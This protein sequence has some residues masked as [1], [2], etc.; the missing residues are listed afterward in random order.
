[1]DDDLVRVGSSNLTNR[2]MGLDAECDLAVE[3]EGIP[4]S[5]KASRDSGTLLPSISERLPERLRRPSPRKD[6]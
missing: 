6:R 5:G 2:S 3:A 4:G 1:V